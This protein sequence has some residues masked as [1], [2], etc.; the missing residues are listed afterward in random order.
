VKSRFIEI[1]REVDTK[2]LIPRRSR[3]AGVPIS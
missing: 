1:G 3:R 2:M